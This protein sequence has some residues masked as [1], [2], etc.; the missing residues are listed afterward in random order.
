MSPTRVDFDSHATTPIDPA[1]RDAMA[2]VWATPHGNPSSVHALGRRAR[3]WIEDAREQ[4]AAALHARRDEIVFTSGGTEAV[5]LAVRATA[6][7]REPQSIWFDPCGHP[8]LAAACRLVANARGIA[9]EPIP[10]R[11]GGEPDLDA[12]RASIL[13]AGR[14]ALVAISWVQHETGGIAPIRALIDVANSV[15]S[16]CLLDGAQAFGKLAVDVGTTGAAAITMSAHKIG[17]P[18]GAGAVWFDGA[19]RIPG[20]GGGGGQERGL[21][22]GTENVAGIVGLGAA[23]AHVGRRVDAM[24]RVGAMR[25][26]IARALLSTPRI[27]LNGAERTRVSTALHVSVEGAAGEELVASF[28]LEGVS[29]SSGPACASGKPEPSAS[30]LA[31]YPDEPWRAS[32]ALRITLGPENTNDDVARFLEVASRV[33]ERVRR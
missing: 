24:V 28:D 19:V 1:A 26:T 6:D 15:E 33:I 18:T 21:R 29:V 30:M 14:R 12:L 10:I 32:S 7:S 8:A 2:N 11:R 17:G 9:C 20:Q 22:A 23:A 3:A 27:A 31:M 13:A 25:D 16:V 4:I 5:H